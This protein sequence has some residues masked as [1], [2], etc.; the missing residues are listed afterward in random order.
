MLLEAQEQNVVEIVTKCAKKLGIN[1]TDPAE[2][3][4]DIDE[5]IDSLIKFKKRYE[6]I[7][8]SI[9]EAMIVKGSFDSIVVYDART[10]KCVPV[11]DWR[12]LLQDIKE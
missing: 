1:K 6:S 5:K 9:K 11:D 2:L 8:K 7:I 4:K 10:N 3:A 12:K